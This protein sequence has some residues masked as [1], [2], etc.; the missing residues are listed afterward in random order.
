MTKQKSPNPENIKAARE[1]LGLTQ[2]RAAEIIGASPV[3]WQKWEY[4]ERNMPPAK[5]ELW[6]IKVRDLK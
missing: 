2:V 1:K 3:A 6:L 4:G 5:W